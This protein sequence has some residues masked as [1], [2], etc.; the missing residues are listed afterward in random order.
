MSSSAPSFDLN[1]RVAIVT[2]GSRGIGRALSLGFARAGA[3]VVVASRKFEPC[4]EVAKEIEEAGGEA[5]AVSAHM[6]ELADL[7]AL[8][9]ATTD[10][11]GAIDIVVNNAANP[12]ALPIG[13]ITP[14]AWEKS[15][16]VNARGPLFLVQYALPY[17]E[18][19]ERAAVINVVTAGVYTNGAYRSLYCSGKAALQMTTRSMA[20]EFASKGIRVNAISPGTIDTTMVRN[21]SEAEQEM[22]ANASPMRRMA[23]P[24]ELVGAAL[25][26]A[27]DAGSFMTGSTVHVD[28]GMIMA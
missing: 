4:A 10:R 28:G 17:L 3:R 21:T 6:G 25:L 24:D 1:G 23:E 22:M 5:L 9:A 27:S 8:V 14:E 16:H 18:Q 2:G 26:L 20:A 13:K 19:S 12:V 7:E 11:F 15:F